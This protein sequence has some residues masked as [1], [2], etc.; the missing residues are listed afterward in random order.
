MRCGIAL[1]PAGVSKLRRIGEKKDKGKCTLCLD[2][3]DVM[4]IFMSSSET[5]KL[6]REVLHKEWLAINKEVADK[7][8]LKCANICRCEFR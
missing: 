5:R 8:I 2:E 3:D 7:K 1:W 4:H 6:R